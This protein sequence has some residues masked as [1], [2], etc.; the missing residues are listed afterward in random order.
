MSETEKGMAHELF[1][2]FGK[3][4]FCVGIQK[5]KDMLKAL[6]ICIEKKEAEKP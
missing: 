3:A 5:T 1:D 2:W 6:M 4:V